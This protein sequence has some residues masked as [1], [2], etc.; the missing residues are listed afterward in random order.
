MID[1]RGFGAALLALGAV[2]AWA[3]QDFPTRT[4]QL[5]VP[6]AP[7]GPT[8]TYAREIAAKLAPVWHQSVVVDNRPGGGT[9]IGTA[10]VAQASGDGHTLLLTSLAFILTPLMT[11]N[12]AF[13]PATLSPIAQIGYA[14]NI[15]YIRRNLAVSSIQEFI[16]YAKAQPSGV[17]FGSSG[18][19]SSVHVGAEMLA[20][21]AG[22]MMT[23]VPYRGSSQ[24]IADLIA[25]NVDAVF[26]TANSMVFA[27][28]GRIKALV[29][30]R[31][32]RSEAE[33]EVPTLRE[34]GIDMVSESWYGLLG[35][36]GMPGPLRD[37]IARDL[38]TV[39]VV[40]ETRDRMLRAGLELRLVGPVDFATSLVAERKSW[41]DLVRERKLRMT[42]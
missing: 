30:G 11:T 20:A 28:D 8:D 3:Q 15:M 33:P 32:A 16:A 31:R 37:R 23:H 40:P 24:A 7:G 18:V 4:V 12:L 14:P 38:M 27:R 1:R 10:A 22:F 17:T 19:G 35:G 41:G 29:S 34:S 26:D 13:D 9:M 42:E 2:P 36:P 5:V 25:G 6:F 39:A 21:K